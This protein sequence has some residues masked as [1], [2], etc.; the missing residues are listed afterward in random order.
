MDLARQFA[1][2]GREVTLITYSD[3]HPSAPP[4][5]RGQTWKPFCPPGCRYIHI[6]PHGSGP[7]RHV[8]R[9]L[10]LRQLLR[11]LDIQA[12]LSVMTYS[13][14]LVSSSLCWSRRPVTHVA[15]EHSLTSAAVAGGTWSQRMQASLIRASARWTDCIVGVSDAVVADL[16]RRRYVRPGQRTV[17][18]PNPVDV[19][20]V[21]LASQEPASVSALGYP[22]LAVLGRLTGAKGH[23]LLFRALASISEPPFVLL[24]GD[25]PLLCDLQKLAA[26]LGL[27][28]RVQFVGWVENPHPLLLRSSGVIMSSRWEGFGLVAVEAAILNLPFLGTDV[29]GLAEVCR[30][31]GYLTVN[32]EISALAG[33]IA[34]LLEDPAAFLPHPG[35]TDVFEPGFCAA[36]YLALLDGTSRP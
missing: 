18:I 9:V 32:P 28:A 27:S 2:A 4:L 22:Y 23:D 30:S 36:R 7:I 16:R 19:S 10:A 6:G 1:I 3:S 31:L 34:R 12:V 24:I 25:G 20:R 35:T 26:E 21:L 13:N 14:L 17:V 33:G 5:L 8:Y 11:Q 15:S 29:G